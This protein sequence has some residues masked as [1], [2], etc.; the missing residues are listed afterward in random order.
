MFFTAQGKLVLGWN[1]KNKGESVMVKILLVMVF[2]LLCVVSC[3]KSD[4]KSG[5]EDDESSQS[6][7]ELYFERLQDDFYGGIENN[8][9]GQ[10][11]DDKVPLHEEVSENGT[12]YAIDES[13]EIVYDLREPSV[14]FDSDN[15]RIWVNTQIDYCP[16]C[17]AYA[18]K[19]DG[20][21][22][23]CDC[24]PRSCAWTLEAELGSDGGSVPIPWDPFWSCK[25][26]RFITDS[27]GNIFFSDW[28]EVK[29]IADDSNYTE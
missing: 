15:D 23:E 1:N 9:H 20:V 5:G 19:F 10:V 21:E 26:R 14:F 22:V 25:F 24:R 18:T 8:D 2:V 4:G 6:I 29:F 13:G 16:G 11:F 3:T 27:N 17:P 12:R 28:G 7:S